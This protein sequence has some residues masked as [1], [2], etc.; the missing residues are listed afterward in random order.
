M[1]SLGDE[2]QSLID[3]SIAKMN[4]W[5]DDK[6]DEYQARINELEDENLDLSDRIIELENII[7]E[8]ENK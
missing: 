3:D 2:A 7:E 8:L 4:S 5:L 6:Q 1:G